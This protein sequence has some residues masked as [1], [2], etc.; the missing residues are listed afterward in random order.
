MLEEDNGN[1]ERPVVFELNAER[2]QQKVA[3]NR[4][5][6]TDAVARFAVCRDRAAMFEASEGGQRMLQ[7]FVG[8]F[9]GK[10]GDESYSAG[11]LVEAR[12]K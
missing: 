1:A 8:G 4:S 9:A 5:H 2:K 12:V 10:L 3:R 11:V 7:D 6:D